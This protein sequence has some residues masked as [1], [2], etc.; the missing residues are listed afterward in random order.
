ML[1]AWLLASAVT[2]ADDPVALQRGREL[3]T[4]ERALSGRIVGHA[5]DLPVPASRCVN[6]HAIQPPAPGPDSSAPGTQAFGPVLTRSGL[7]QASSRRGGPASRYDEAAF[8]R[9]LRTGIDPA[10]V[11]ILRAMPRYVLTDADCR[12]LWVHLTEQSVR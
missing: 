9:V 8:C 10:H 4:G 6:C 11:I 12:A 7:T 5:A 3:F 1:F 2:A